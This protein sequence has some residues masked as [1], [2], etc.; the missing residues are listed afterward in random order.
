MDISRRSFM[1]GAAA[2]AMVP[3]VSLAKTSRNIRWDKTV[4]VLIAGG[5]LAGLSAAVQA[6]ESG[7]KKVLLIEKNLFLGGHA[8][9]SGGGFVAC[10]TQIQ[11]NAGIE[12]SP[13]KDWADAVKRGTAGNN[14][15]KFDTAVARMIFDKQAEAVEWLQKQG[16]KFEDKPGYGYGNEKRLHYFAPQGP[17]G[18]SAALTALAE[19]AKKKKVEIQTNC[20]LVEL[21]TRDRTLGSP[22][23]GAVIQ[24]K[25]GKKLNVQATCGVILASGGF[26]KNPEMVKRYHPYLEGVSC[27][28]YPSSTGDGITAALALGASINVTHN[29]L[30]GTF[31]CAS[32]ADPTVRVNGFAPGNMPLAIVNKDGRRFIDESKGGR[33]IAAEMIIA[34]HNPTFWIFDKKNLDQA[35]NKWFK[36]LFN[37]NLV[38]E[39][40]T[41]EDLAK[42]E[43]I[44]AKNLKKL[45][46]D[47]NEDA[48]K[49]KDR[50]F[51][52]TKLLQ[53]LDTAPF[54]AFAAEPTMLYT[55]T[56]L[57]INTKCQ[58]LDTEHKPIP[59]LY[60]AGDI[61]GRWDAI[62]GLGQGGMSGLSLATVTGR[63][64]GEQTG[65][66]C[67]KK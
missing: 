21:I 54:C 29:D 53:A 2:A 30:A 58:V 25:D 24:T 4:Q 22:V 60:A 63:V 48:G 17:K 50:V 28:S 18:N 6:R 35:K 1:A 56:G 11:K 19:T 33:Y 67:S 34:K 55:Y 57:L 5:G 62:V 27:F 36:A 13:D 7:C 51:G 12:D 46:E 3:A 10:G 20:K 14:F 64:A 43:G 9:I 32:K 37:K 44:N 40:A 41:I 52:K 49:G 26:G 23:V 39:Y 47:Y 59:G 45:V 8:L 42:G 61:S 16:V 31:S 65:L 15:L 38:H 66:V